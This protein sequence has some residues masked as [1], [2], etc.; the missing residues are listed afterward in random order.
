MNDLMTTGGMTIGLDL[1]DKWSE[2]CVVD[3][4]GRTVLRHRMRTTRDGF[5]ELSKHGGARVVIEAGTHSPWVSRHLAARGFEVVVA[6]RTRAALIARRFEERRVRC[7]GVGAA[8]ARGSAAAPPIAHRSETTQRDRILVQ[9]RDGLVR[10]RTQLI[11]VRGLRN[12]WACAS[13][14]V[15]QETFAKRTA[16][17]RA[18]RSLP[19]CAVLLKRSSGSRTKRK[20]GA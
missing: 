2:A 17:R 18:G 6:N 14:V 5:E 20:A 8:Q 12:R 3:E 1:G 19:G 16:R 13:R 7:G 4:R 15:R 10:A 9:A 11:Q